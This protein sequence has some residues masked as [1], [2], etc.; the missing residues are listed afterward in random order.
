MPVKRE[1]LGKIIAL[2][3]VFYI[4]FATPWYLPKGLETRIAGIPAWGF[5]MPFVTCILGYIITFVA[6][7]LEV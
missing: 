6:Y 4:I 3:V 1:N 5:L 7:K 2:L